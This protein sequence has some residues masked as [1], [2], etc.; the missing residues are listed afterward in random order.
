MIKEEKNEEKEEEIIENNEYFIINTYLRPFSYKLIGLNIM[1]LSLNSNNKFELKKEKKYYDKF[2]KNIEDS[3]KEVLGNILQ[4][5]KQN[6]EYKEEGYN[7]FYK[8]WKIYKKNYDNNSIIEL[9]K[10][11]IMS[12][13]FLLLPEEY[14]KRKDE[15]YP[16]EISRKDL[17]NKKIY[18]ENLDFNIKER[19]HDLYYDEN[20]IFNTNYDEFIENRINDIKKN[21]I[22]NYTTNVES[23][24]NDSNDK[25]IEMKLE[26]FKINFYELKYER[27]E[28]NNKFFIY[29]PLSFSFLFY[30]KDIDF[31]KKS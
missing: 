14:E 13:M 17:N 25:K 11:E 15:Q 28:K 5:L 12:T 10:D 29:L 18:F 19:Y 22:K 20:E 9:I 30:Y 16:Q 6:I 7:K 2:L 3:Y 31:L 4:V 26:S 24:F 1:N 21:K 23:S 8:Q 27:D